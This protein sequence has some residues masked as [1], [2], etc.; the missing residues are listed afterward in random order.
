MI[1]DVEIYLNLSEQNGY[2]A[3][4]D[5]FHIIQFPFGILGFNFLTKLQSNQMKINILKYCKL[6][7]L[8]LDKTKNQIFNKITYFNKNA[9]NRRSSFSPYSVENPYY[10]EIKV[11][12]ISLS[13]QKET[14][15]C[16]IGFIDYF[17]KRMI[18]KLSLD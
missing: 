6:I 7:N 15:F 17:Y 1:F 16:E 18:N 10:S 3:L 8:L 9:M 4:T 13:D 2:K 14:V 5:E 12:K 11:L